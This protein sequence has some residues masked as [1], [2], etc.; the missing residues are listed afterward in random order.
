MMHLNFGVRA[1]GGLKILCMGA[2][3]DDIEIGCGGTL[4]RIADQYPECEFHWVVF[5]AIATR[6]T[7]AR[8]AAQLFA[9]SRLR[10]PIFKTFQDGFMPYVGG[11]VKA[12]FESD[13]KHLSPDLIFT[14]NGNDAHQ[15]HR[16]ISQLTWNTFRDHFILEYEIP[17]YDGD[18]GRPS[19]FVPLEKEVCEKK[20]EYLMNA[21]Q[22]QHAK[23][24][25][26]PDTFLSLMRLRGMECAASSGYAE[27][28]YCRKLSV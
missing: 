19:F 10:G 7:E 25:F 20:V 2:H 1:G 13:L 24:W 27:A 28:F 26:Q 3:S 12:I 5:N 6:E 15:D 18:M 21:F 22:S 23:R 11:E 14:H 4:L 17:K 16:F 9:G 8:H